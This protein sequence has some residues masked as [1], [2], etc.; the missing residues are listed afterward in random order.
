L[1]SFGNIVIL[2]GMNCII[3]SIDGLHRG[4][5]GCFG[6]T[7]IQTPAADTLAAQSVLF[8]GYH[9][10]TLKLSASLSS[11]WNYRKTP[12]LQTLAEQGIETFWLT[13][14][15]ALFL[16]EHTDGFSK[17]FYINRFDADLPVDTLE[18]TEFY[19]SVLQLIETARRQTK[20]WKTNQDKQ[21]FL[22]MHLP[23][24]RG[25]WDFPSSYRNKHRHIKD[26]PPPYMEVHPPKFLTVDSPENIGFYLPDRIQSVVEAYSGGIAVLDDSLAMLLDAAENGDFGNNTAIILFSVRGF[27]IA[28]HGKI[29]ITDDYYSENIGLPL[30]IR[31]PQNICAENRSSVLLT[32]NDLAEFFTEIH[33]GI[34]KNPPHIA[35][36]VLENAEESSLRKYIK[37]A[38]T[39]S[40]KAVITPDWFFRQVSETQLSEQKV[41]FE[42]YVK[43]DDYWEV[44]NVA[45]R[46][47]E[48]VESLVAEF[49]SAEC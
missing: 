5:F 2:N 38:G 8:D 3:I 6:N 39:S 12:V 26:D 19:R 14:S 27:S 31:F 22:W 36:L 16:N 46:C 17:R 45:S 29:G 41:T 9:T 32:Q 48:I 23:G 11:L 15:E 10:S 20:H 40:Q 33:S 47:P 28:E 30:F 21:F 44:N 37:F 42:L 49:F 43:P 25:L 35:S 7:W 34:D 1:D 13:S 18:Q 4:F 24:F